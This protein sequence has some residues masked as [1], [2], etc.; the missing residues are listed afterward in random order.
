MTR[1]YRIRE[2]VNAG[3]TSTFTV[4]SKEYLL[5]F[6]ETATGYDFDYG[7]NIKMS[8]STL[9]E[10]QQEVDKLKATDE[11]LAQY[12]KASKIVKTRYHGDK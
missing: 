6:W 10:A 7:I 1:R 11:I 5:S 2:D 4:E 3:G 9:E 12:A 8:F